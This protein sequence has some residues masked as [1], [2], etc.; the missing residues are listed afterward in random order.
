MTHPDNISGQQP[1]SSSAIKAENVRVFVDN[2]NDEPGFVDVV[3]P[4]EMTH[5]EIKQVVGTIIAKQR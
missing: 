3:E 5:E 4:R 1:I 2:G